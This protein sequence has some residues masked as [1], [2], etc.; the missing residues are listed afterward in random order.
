MSNL[1]KWISSLFLIGNL[2]GLIS[3][4]IIAM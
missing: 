4:K 2:A 3:E 1:N